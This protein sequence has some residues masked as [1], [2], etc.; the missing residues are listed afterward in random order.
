MKG[1]RAVEAVPIATT[2][3]EIKVLYLEALTLV[4]R[5]HRRLLVTRQRARF[6]AGAD[7]F[8]L[9]TDFDRLP[10]SP[11]LNLVRR[12]IQMSTHVLLQQ[13]DH[14]GLQLYGRLGA[15]DSQALRRL[16][17]MA[18]SLAFGLFATGTP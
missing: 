16:C 12:A 15:S 11:D 3:S 5:L 8:G 6:S 13:P 7:V 2:A 14:I 17:E 4:E 1:K 10:S 18:L 9:L